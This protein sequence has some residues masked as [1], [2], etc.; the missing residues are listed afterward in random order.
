M[1]ADRLF[2]VEPSKDYQAEKMG[3]EVVGFIRS[4]QISNIAHPYRMGEH[5]GSI[6]SLQYLR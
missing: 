1:G 6:P 3:S 2:L 5:S 4:D